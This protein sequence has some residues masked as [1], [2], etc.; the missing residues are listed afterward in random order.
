MLD[1]FEVLLHLHELANL[2]LLRKGLYKLQVALTLSS[3]RHQPTQ[4]LPFTSV[5]APDRLTSKSRLHGVEG[6]DAASEPGRIDDETLV[7]NSRS[8]V[9]RYTDERFSLNEQA[10]FRCEVPRSSRGRNKNAL[11]LRITLFRADCGPPPSADD[12]NDTTKST[13]A[14][15]VRL[16]EFERVSV[17]SIDISSLIAPAST[18]AGDE[19]PLRRAYIPVVFDASYLACLGLSVHAQHVTTRF[20]APPPPSV[21]ALLERAR[22]P[23]AQSHRSDLGAASRTS[24]FTDDHD[25][26]SID[27][28]RGSSLDAFSDG[29][30]DG[31]DGGSVH[32]AASL[33]P[34]GTHAARG[35]V[36][37]APRASVS[38]PTEGER[39]DDDSLGENDGSKH[40]S[41]QAQ[42]AVGKAFLSWTQA[43]DTQS[44]R[45]PSASNGRG[46]PAGISGSA[47][48][49]VSRLAGMARGLIRAAASYNVGR[50]DGE[51]PDEKGAPSV[52]AGALDSL[53]GSGKDDGASAVANMSQDKAKQRKRPQRRGGKA[54]KGMQAA[55]GPQ[56]LSEALFPRWM[57]QTHALSRRSSLALPAAAATGFPP[58][59]TEEITGAH[60][61]LVAPALIS[62][63][64]L[65]AFR[66]EL[67]ATVADGIAAQ[68][69]HDIS[70]LR[71]F[72]AARH[73]RTSSQSIVGGVADSKPMRPV[74]WS[75]GVPVQ[76]PGYCPTRFPYGVRARAGML[77]ASP[78]TDIGADESPLSACVAASAAAAVEA[79]REHRSD[80]PRAA[81]VLAALLEDAAGAS[82]EQWRALQRELTQYP[83]ASVGHLQASHRA[84]AMARMRVNEASSLH[85]SSRRPSGII[86]LALPAGSLLDPAPAIAAAIDPADAKSAPQPGAAAQPMALYDGKA[87]V[88]AVG[89]HLASVPLDQPLF[90][91][92]RDVNVVISTFT[93]AAQ[94]LVRSSSAGTA[95]FIQP[96]AVPGALSTA[97]PV[98][99]ISVQAAEAAMI[100]SDPAL[101]ASEPV[102]Q[103]LR[104]HSFASGGRDL[105]S[106]NCDNV[107]DQDAGDSAV[108][109]SPAQPPADA[110]ADGDA[111]PSP[112]L[113]APATLDA[114]SEAAATPLPR[115]PMAPTW[116]LEEG[117]PSPVARRPGVGVVDSGLAAVA[118]SASS[119]PSLA[120][121]PSLFAS[122]PAEGTHVVIFLNGL[123]G[124]PH[125][126]RLLRSYLKVHQPQLASYAVECHQAKA[127]E[128]CIIASAVKVAEE[129]GRILTTKV[130]D[131]GL[132]PIGRIS[133]VAFSLGGLVARLALRHPSLW[134]F[135]PRL[136]AFVSV[137][138][139][140]LGLLYSGSQIVSAGM[141]LFQRLRGSA[142][143]A[144]LA[145]ADE[146]SSGPRGVR[147]CLLYLLACG[148]TPSDPDEATDVEGASST[149][150]KVRSFSDDGHGT[151]EDDDGSG[152]DDALGVAI[153]ASAVAGS[154]T[155][156]RLSAGPATPTLRALRAGKFSCESNGQLMRHFRH[157][158][159]L[160]SPQD[161]YAPAPSCGVHWT[162]NALADPRNGHRYGEMLRGFFDGMPHACI[163]RID[164]AFKTLPSAAA[165]SAAAGAREGRGAGGAANAG[166][167][168]EDD[169]AV[170]QRGSDDG[171]PTMADVEGLGASGPEPGMLAASLS[172]LGL[173]TGGIS[174]AIDSVLGRE[175]H[176]AFLE[177]PA[178]AALVALGLDQRVW[179]QPAHVQAQLPVPAPS[180]AR[181]SAISIERRVPIASVL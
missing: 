108:D 151:D 43:G 148:W 51:E 139:P 9:L 123:G 135:K 68:R 128:G 22:A 154:G 94:L 168:S 159:L 130:A 114:G 40:E 166:E 124:S 29:D 133:F 142:A 116:T 163:T 129:V 104:E 79:L 23:T 115:S 67:Q 77:L 141:F 44:S 19:L 56:S 72:H 38:A 161:G 15:I 39:P 35:S 84:A 60:A 134:P 83:F 99:S 41:P 57:D 61:Q 158:V 127:T 34:G 5:A 49:A 90:T 64:Q 98:A 144:Q 110:G 30:D 11:S 24:S 70:R 157:V 95:Q 171:G 37:R 76:G 91:L 180:P 3:N 137:A 45:V 13:R 32:S 160:S 54:G 132:A 111:S 36:A 165:A 100:A 75:D 147:D 86:R 63:F 174:K 105:L 177:S 74:E 125:D 59:T 31:T 10:S 69:D 102:M 167:S 26:G 62:A 113:S 52:A 181:S 58:L 112:A 53:A 25:A 170:R 93:A 176:V 107:S 47:K 152:G 173:V 140:H 172:R 117:G 162:A 4:C 8:V 48:A 97:G 169:D 149:E 80:P 153:S 6:T 85:A 78:F 146:P 103:H 87:A 82:Y 179:G 109:S 96:Q 155:S 42:G 18:S 175:A 119:L 150:A 156:P 178:V 138:S 16:G 17:T 81:Q 145:F 33:T 1:V 88:T 89:K 20:K 50:P 126:T 101:V 21:S 164:V 27:G 106:D 131:D 46:N 73:Q 55:S 92:R 136:H 66:A 7:Y 2:E 118:T 14:G 143:L 121:L 120:S 71:S 12:D 65:Q 28:D 122:P